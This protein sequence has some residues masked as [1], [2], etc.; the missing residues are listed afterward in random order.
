[1]AARRPRGRSPNARSEATACGA[2]ARSRTASRTA[3]PRQAADK[4]DLNRIAKAT[5]LPERL[6]SP[7]AQSDGIALS[8]PSK[9]DDP[10]GHLG[11]CRIIPIEQLQVMQRVFE[12][13]C[14]HRDRVWCEDFL[15]VFFGGLN[16]HFRYDV[17]TRTFRLATRSDRRNDRELREVYLTIQ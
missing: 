11:D 8:L 5:K 6:N 10:F 14:E 7:V 13:G 1:L 2:S 17:E 9:L 16:G 12:R 3:R 4:A 15:I